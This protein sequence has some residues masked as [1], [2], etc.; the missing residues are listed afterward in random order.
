MSVLLLVFDPEVCDLRPEIRPPSLSSTTPCSPFPYFREVYPHLTVDGTERG[1]WT[2]DPVPFSGQVIHVARYDREP[3][4]TGVVTSPHLPYR[5]WT[6]LRNWGPSD[7]HSRELVTQVVPG[8]DIS[9]YSSVSLDRQGT[10]TLTC[11]TQTSVVY[12]S[13]PVSVTKVC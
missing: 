12:R 13:V 6:V 10:G 11:P 4:R 1:L 2:E 7:Q 9:L 3:Q 5:Q 8:V